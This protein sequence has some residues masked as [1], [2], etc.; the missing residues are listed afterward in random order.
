MAEENQDG[1]KRPKNPQRRLREAAEENRILTSKEA[2]V[3]TT[4]AAGL[5]LFMAFPHFL[6]FA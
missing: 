4:L 5:V 2:M 6:N 3:F 1:R